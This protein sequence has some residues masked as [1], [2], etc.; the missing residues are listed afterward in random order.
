VP[1][2]GATGGAR[3]QLSV[4]YHQAVSDKSYF[5]SKVNKN[6]NNLWRP[7]ERQSI[8]DVSVRYIVTP[9]ISVTAILPIVDNNFSVLY[10]PL[11]AA[12]G[13]RS[14]GFANG[15]GDIS[16]YAQSWLFNPR[17]HPF[18]NTALGV[19][20]KLPTGN[21]DVK[22]TL[23]NENG[24]GF[25]KRAVY[26]PAIM[27]GDG[28]TGIIFGFDSWKTI[29]SPMFLRGQTVFA[30]ASYL[31]NPRDTNGTQSI[32]AGLGVPLAPQFANALTNSVTDSYSLSVGTSVKLPYAWDKP[33]LKGLRGRLTYHWEGIPV[34][35]LIG[36]SDGYRQ[37]GYAMAISPGFT[38]AYGR[39]LLICE[40]PITFM[41]YIYPFNSAIPGLPSAKG[42]PAVFNPSRNLGM[43][44][45]VALTLRC[46]RSF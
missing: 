30:S 7:H 33:K 20:I 2:L 14:A 17:N 29:R 32:V 31:V 25:M 45:P 42:A 39:N 40:A 34:R 44:A 27:P 16:L 46:V 1:G 28:G 6:F 18:G 26:P 10:P 22:A 24:L 41:Q 5:Q 21:W 9:R 19:G 38:Y 11:T 4:G 36:R 43:I 15:I 35:D 8:L 12:R 13:L 3:F 23:P 37:P